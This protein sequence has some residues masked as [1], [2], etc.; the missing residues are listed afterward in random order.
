MCRFFSMIVVYVADKNYADYVNIS[1]KTLL[2]YND[3]KI[4]V[5][6]PEPI[7]TEY[8]NVVIPLGGEYKHR[9]H[10][11]ITDATY[12]KLFLTQLPYDKII[13]LDGDTLVLQPLDEL[14]K[15]EPEYIA[16]TESHDYGKTQAEDLGVKKYGLSGLMVMNLKK[17]RE[18]NFTEKCLSA[19]P[20]V[21]KWFHEETLINYILK[22]KLQFI[23]CK[24]NWCFN[25]EYC[26]KKAD[27]I[28][29]LHI[30]GR[31]KSA[32]YTYSNLPEIKK[33]IKGKSVA[34]VG[35]AKSIFDK[36]N[37]DEIDNHDII[38][39]FNRGFVTK[40]ESQGTK[41][42]IV[43]LACEL[44]VDEK[45]TYKAMYYLNRSHNTRCGNDTISN[46]DRQRLRDAIGKQPSS[47]FM[48]IDLCLEAKSI[49]LYGFD[50]G[51]TPTFY[52]PE[53]YIT[54]HDY[55]KEKQLILKMRNINIH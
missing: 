23:D 12:L 19:N 4:I 51:Q 31:N 10:D 44:T 29:I 53:G 35:N 36:E 33:Y 5:V 3:A 7:E 21:K 32:M 52:N 30:C 54:Q 16:L 50:F 15:L 37:G 38:I 9:A 48:A 46:I 2:R 27:D 43:I 55:N 34:I 41:T 28:K 18:I 13:Y 6:S 42:H 45:L 22:D 17:L 11:R 26:D 40:P 25:R 14:W 8:E 47:G 24:W 39:R 49:D 1:A 20:E